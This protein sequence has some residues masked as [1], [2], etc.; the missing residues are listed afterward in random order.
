MIWLY[1]I[2]GL[3]GLGIVVYVVASIKDWGASKE[4]EDRIEAENAKLTTT[5]K[6]IRDV[7][8][9]HDSIERDTVERSRL[10]DKYK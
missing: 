10:R 2:L 6:D 3:G 9:I 1:S 5:L 7:K 4:R 8:K